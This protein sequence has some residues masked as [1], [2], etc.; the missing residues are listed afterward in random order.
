MS[1][2]IQVQFEQVRG[3][4]ADLTGQLLT[5]QDTINEGQRDALSSFRGYTDGASNAIFIATTEE[6]ARQAIALTALT[7]KLLNF[8]RNSTDIVEEEDKAIG[9]I[10]GSF[11]NTTVPTMGPALPPADGTALTG[12]RI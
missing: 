5:E 6:S 2:T 9:I 8:I 1:N 10:F 3:L 7:E 11:N 4:T 12:P